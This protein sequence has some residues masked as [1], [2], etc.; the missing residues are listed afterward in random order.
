MH[1]LASIVVGL[2]LLVAACSSDPAVSD[3]TNGTNKNAVDG[4]DTAATDTGT[5]NGSTTAGK[6]S[7]CLNDVF[8]AC[9][10]KT[11]F[12][13]CSG[14]AGNI[15]DCIAACDPMD[16]GCQAS[17][18]KAGSKKPD[19]SGCAKQEGEA[20]PGGGGGG[21]TAICTG[22]GGKACTAD[23][24][25]GSGNHCTDGHC[26]DNT[27]DTKCTADY[28]CGSGNHCTDGCCQS[29]TE[30]TTCTAD[31]QCGSG[32]H[33]TGGACHAN[34]SGSPCTADYQCGSGGNCT[35]GKCQ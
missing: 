9:P 1:N 7:C 5:A 23:Y 8:Y 20:C 14:G 21:G 18:S 13:A 34:E 6:F 22:I 11:K 35:S 4:T 2:G 27:T 33:C 28:Q 30:G 29:N 26:F 19:P 17:C 12:D 16:A 10:D 15:G 31:Y 32:N 25:C 24:Q 3:G